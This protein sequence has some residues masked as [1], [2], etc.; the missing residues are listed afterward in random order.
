MKPTIES[1]RVKEV[2]YYCHHSSKMVIFYIASILTLGLVYLIFTWF[3]QLYVYLYEEKGSLEEAD[4]LLVLRKD[5]STVLVKISKGLMR[6]LPNVPKREMYYVWF[7]NQL[8]YLKEGNESFVIIE[9]LMLEYLAQDPKNVLECLNGLDPAI[10]KELNDFYGENVID[11]KNR[12]YL[13]FFFEDFFSPVIMFQMSSA[14]IFGF[15]GY[16]VYGIVLSVFIL[17]ATIS[18]SYDKMV[19]SR[20]MRKMAYI[21]K[22]VK[23]F[24]NINGGFQD[25]EISS[26]DLVIGDLV[27]IE[28]GQ[29]FTADMV[30]LRGTCLVS[31]A[32]LTG[33][34][35]PIRKT[36]A[37]GNNTAEEDITIRSQ[38]ILNCGSKCIMNKS[39]SVQAVVVKTAWNT[40]KGELIANIL[41]SKPAEFKFKRD[42]FLVLGILFA[43]GCFFI[44]L[45]LLIKLRKGDFQWKNFIDK[46]LEIL[47]TA[48]P[49]ALILSFTVGIKTA[50]TR[51]KQ[52]NVLPVIVDKINEA[53]RVKYVCFDKTGTL[54]EMNVRIGGVLAQEDME[55]NDIAL[56]VSELINN[57]NYKAIMEVM[58]C[59]HSLQ[60][61][62]DKVGG[63]PLDEEIFAHTKFILKEEQ[64]G[65]ET[66]RFI[67]PTKDYRRLYTLSPD[68]KYEVLDIHE[69]TPERRCMSVRVADSKSG[70]QLILV[71]GAPERIKAIATAESIPENYDE[72]LLEY[73]EKG[74]RIIS[75]GV[76]H[77][78]KNVDENTKR[79]VENVERDI[80]FVGFV[81]L[82]NP[83]KPETKRTIAELNKNDIC[84]KMI[85]GDNI[86]TAIN[87][88]CISGI[89]NE[90]ENIFIGTFDEE[91]KIYHFTYFSNN[92]IKNRIAKDDFKSHVFHD[93]MSRRTIFHEFNETSL[94]HV[95]DKCAVMEN[96]RI[97]VEGKVFEEIFMNKA[98]LDLKLYEKFFEYAVIFGRTSPKQKEAIVEALKHALTAKSSVYCVAYVGDGSNDS[99]A[100]RVANVGLSLGSNES[101]IASAF[102]TRITSIEPLVDI[103]IEGRANLELA[104]QNFKFIMITSIFQFVSISLLGIYHLDYTTADYIY[105]DNLTIIPIALLM[106][107]THASDK[108]NRNLPKVSIFN[109]EIIMSISGHLFFGVFFVVMSINLLMGFR[110]QKSVT[111]SIGDRSE[112][113]M[114]DYRFYQNKLMIF[115]M[116]IISI[117][118]CYA[119]SHAYPFRKSVFTNYVLVIY[120]TILA[121]FHFAMLYVDEIDNYYFSYFMIRFTQHPILDDSL[122]WQFVSFT[123]VASLVAFCYEGTNRTYFQKKK[124]EQNHILRKIK[125]NEK[126]TK[127]EMEMNTDFLFEVVSV[128]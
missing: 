95:L 97:A 76:K 56:K 2:H 123:V 16:L 41:N 100:L 51:L 94:E 36:G 105:F 110:L 4:V 77:L 10:V 106:C 128:N 118:I 103:L 60:I 124:R 122:R 49:P 66:R 54:T 99:R 115:F 64:E 63:D 24:R 57:K 90:E 79:K 125:R 7:D 3:P 112:F 26:K 6:Y 78:G 116:D 1:D 71:K 9:N 109:W 29:D 37:I 39:Q 102:N 92:E 53:G 72:L 50:N 46:S 31:E 89:I 73:S 98:N 62:H 81:L 8:Y 30:L 87:V 45:L 44:L 67:L 5:Q 82:T 108:L 48:L 117:V 88:S 65:K 93:N 11:I 80:E 38:N 58:S 61:L 47:T 55:R 114:D 59:C 27:H 32:I 33:E 20:K 52:K 119:V 86:Y 35:N 74:Y 104:M 113:L 17:A 96:T 15:I 91:K 70:D 18:L 75:L 43:L 84:C 111:E 120:T 28:S 42:L 69:F 68:F 21:D 83:L 14:V 25:I 22:P 126:L 101:S 19:A 127:E 85:T 121:A 13:E 34:P 40:S 12:S 107:Y 23:V